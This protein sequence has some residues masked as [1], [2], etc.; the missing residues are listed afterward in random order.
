MKC[1]GVKAC[2]YL[3]PEIQNMQHAEVTT[4]MLQK[5]EQIRQRN[6]ADSRAND[7]NRS[8]HSQRIENVFVTYFSSFYHSVLEDFEKQKA[9]HSP[10]ETC[11]P[12]CITEASEVRVKAG[13][14]YEY[15][16]NA[17][18]HCP[19]YQLETS[20]KASSYSASPYATSLAI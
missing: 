3:D 16:A 10:V 14:Y 6:G 1:T 17:L 7:V 4:E 9:C 5:I 20:L 8:V 11:K 2:E 15:V 13:M 18:D 19:M 12:V